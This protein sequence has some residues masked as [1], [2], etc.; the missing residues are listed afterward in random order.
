MTQEILLGSWKCP[1]GNTVDVQC[2][3]DDQGRRHVW[4]RWDNPPPLTLDDQRYYDEVICP[5]VVSETLRTLPITPVTQL[6]RKDTTN[7]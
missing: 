5:Q 3:Y 2:S 7:D 4:F 1:S 6:D